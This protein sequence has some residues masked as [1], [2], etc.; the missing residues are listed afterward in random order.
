MEEIPVK[1]LNEEIAMT[2]LEDYVTTF[3]SKLSKQLK[4]IKKPL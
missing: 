3:D 1:S 2:Q 4:K